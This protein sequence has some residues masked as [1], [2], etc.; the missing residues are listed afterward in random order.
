MQLHHLRS[1][2]V[3]I[4]LGSMAAAAQTLGYSAPA[5]SQHI[6]ALEREYGAKLVHR[7]ARGVVATTA[8][9]VLF[10]RGEA[11]LN[12][13]DG[14]ANEINDI[15]TQPNRLRVGAFSTAAQHLLPPTLVTFPLKHPGVDVQLLDREPPDGY[16][17]VT[18]GRLDLL[19]TH[20]YPGTAEPDRQGLTLQPILEDPIE[21]HAG[22]SDPAFLARSIVELADAQW[23]SGPE[24][25]PNRIALNA[26]AQAAGFAPKVRFETTD[27]TV[28]LV[29]ASN[30]LGPCFVARLVA[31]NVPQQNTRV[32]GFV[33]PIPMI[34][35]IGLVY[36]SPVRSEPL[37]DLIADITA[38]A[39]NAIS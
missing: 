8:G 32:P 4:R 18:A 1:F 31:N 20:R 33:P 9:A 19:I 36:R 13:A 30:G 37:A 38:T 10:E 27:Y 34:R 29:L 2:L 12:Q 24:G 7:H 16:D 21:L 14:I 39:A 11:L 15:V 6:A 22:P 17:D 5:I 28:S 26:A 25:A 3:T 23:I 35:S